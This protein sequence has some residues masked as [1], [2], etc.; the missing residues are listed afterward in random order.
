MKNAT[1]TYGDESALDKRDHTI[2]DLLMRKST[3]LAGVLARL[4]RGG[5]PLTAW[6]GV[7]EFRTLHLDAA[8]RTLKKKYGW[9]IESVEIPTYKPDGLIFFVTGYKLPQ[10]AIDQAYKNTRVGNWIEEVR[11]EQ[12]RK[13][14]IDDANAAACESLRLISGLAPIFRNV[15]R[16]PYRR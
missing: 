6:D 16:C 2:G 8:I 4:L 7:E 5:S 13:R 14:A 9:P 11:V 1:I 3:V 12:V 10:A 15:A